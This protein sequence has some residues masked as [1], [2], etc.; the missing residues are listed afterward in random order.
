M[1]FKVKLP[2]FSLLVPE[3][4]RHSINLKW[5][6]FN[7]IWNDVTMTSFS[8]FFLEV[9]CFWWIFLTMEN[10]FCPSPFSV[11]VNH[12]NWSLTHTWWRSW[13]N[14]S[15]VK[16]ITSPCQTSPVLHTGPP[17]PHKLLYLFYMSVCYSIKLELYLFIFIISGPRNISAKEE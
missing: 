12:G 10:V 6:F 15:S 9:T 3:H 17:L 1:N 4:S 5:I 7:L 16:F 2:L 11:L 14:S 8:I 13:N